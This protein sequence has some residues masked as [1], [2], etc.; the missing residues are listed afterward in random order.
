MA[1]CWILM[2]ETLSADIVVVHMSTFNVSRNVTVW[3]IYSYHGKA[4]A[5][6]KLRTSPLVHRQ[7]SYAIKH[8]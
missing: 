3:N 6:E 1:E 5:S 7:V 4:I 8:M 2:L